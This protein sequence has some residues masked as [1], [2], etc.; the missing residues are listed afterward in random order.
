MDAGPVAEALT[1]LRASVD[2]LLAVSLSGQS[3]VEVAS[4]L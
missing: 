1:L 3:S 2:R 4:V